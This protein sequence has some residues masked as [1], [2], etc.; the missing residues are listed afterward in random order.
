MD[1]IKLLVHEREE[2]GNGPARRLRAKGTVPG[3]TYGKGK[4]ATPVSIDLADLRA[5][6]AHGQNMVL[7]LDFGKGARSAK[8]KTARYAMVKELQFHPTKRHLLHVDLHEVDLSVEIEAPVAIEAVGTAP[9]IV[10]GGIMEWDRREVLVRALPVDVPQLL[11]L[12]VSELQLGRHLSV[13]ALVAP[14]GVTIVD[15]PEAVLVALVPPRVEQVPVE[16]EAVEEE[17]EEPEV[18][19]SDTSEE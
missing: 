9:G 16:E 1:T 17:M 15:D 18:I 8:G 7:E 5:A 2:T 19:S 12:D 13:A 14:A 10:D 6:L 11:E 3:V 4:A